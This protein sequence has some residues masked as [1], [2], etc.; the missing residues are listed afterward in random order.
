MKTP[1]LALPLIAMFAMTACGNT[2]STTTLEKAEI[3][4]IVYEYIMDNPGIIIEALEEFDRRSTMEEIMAYENVI[5]EGNDFS[6]GPKDAKVTIVE[7][8]DYNCG[9]CRY[10]S[11]WLQDVLDEHPDDVRVIFKELPIRDSQT[12]TSKSAARMALA[13][14]RQG[15]YVDMHF[16]LMNAP[17]VNQATIDKLAKEM[18]LDVQKLKADAL[19]PAI[20]EQI[21][22]NLSLTRS[23]SSLRGT[24]F[25][26]VNDNYVPSADTD[27]LQDMLDEALKS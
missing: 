12:G 3:E 20:T 8:F 23:L 11:D 9:P 22:T 27:A 2:S 5:F 10:A 14:A 19:D 13:S 4:E 24:P 18:G 17:D 26:I 1:T 25:F 15:K 6:I 7:F 16:A 21:N